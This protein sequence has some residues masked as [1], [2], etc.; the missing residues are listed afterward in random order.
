VIINQ[1]SI[2]R[3]SVPLLLDPTYSGAKFIDRYGL[4]A[5]LSKE[6]YGLKYLS[7]QSRSEDLAEPRIRPRRIHKRKSLSDLECGNVSSA[8]Y[9]RG[10]DD[11]KGNIVYVIHRIIR[12]DPNYGCL[13]QWKHCPKSQRSFVPLAD[14]PESC[15]GLA[16]EAIKR[17]EKRREK[18]KTAHLENRFTKDCCV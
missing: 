4:T 16:D 7:N 17:F 18:Y 14:I 2:Q 10:F 1:E 6:L 15:I 9:R 8:D 3:R 13:V 11:G 5:I 12:F